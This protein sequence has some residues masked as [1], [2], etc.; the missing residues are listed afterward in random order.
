M[1]IY[2]V[3]RGTAD[4]THARYLRRLATADAAGAG[5]GLARWGG[6]GWVLN[7]RS[8]REIAGFCC[9]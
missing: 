3:A 7:N 4:P 8:G 1:H 9:L 2:T 5:A 6:L